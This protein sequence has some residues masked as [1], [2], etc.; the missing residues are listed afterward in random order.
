MGYN[1]GILILNDA[2]GDLNNPETRTDWIKAI[3]AAMHRMPPINIARCYID[4]PIGNHVN[5]SSV[6]HMA[7]ADEVGVYAI[8]GNF[9]S[10]LG[11]LG[12]V[13]HHRPQDQL[14]IL[15]FLANQMGYKL[16]PMEKR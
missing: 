13:N 16:V 9:V 4:V 11:L 8:G 14:E 7:H 5:G 12:N 2:I 6:F 1:T 3:N 15:R 10:R